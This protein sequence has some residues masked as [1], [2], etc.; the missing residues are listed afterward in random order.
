MVW[1]QNSAQLLGWILVALVVFVVCNLS[2]RKTI[3]TSEETNVAHEG[4]ICIAMGLIVRVSILHDCVST[5][6][7]LIAGNDCH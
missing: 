4:F 5:T 2:Q 6:L 1:C 3:G 7:R